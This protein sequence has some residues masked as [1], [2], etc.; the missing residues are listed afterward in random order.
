MHK[1]WNGQ[2]Y[3]YFE[4]MVT[5]TKKVDGTWAFDYGVFDKWVEMTV[6]DG[7]GNRTTEQFEFVW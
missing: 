5:W 3:D 7:C 2:T 6:T 1:P 4:S